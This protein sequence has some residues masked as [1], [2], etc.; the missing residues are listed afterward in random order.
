M[1]DYGGENAVSLKDAIYH[2]LK[3]YGMDEETKSKLL[4]GVCCDGAAVNLGCVKGITRINI[5][6]FP[7]FI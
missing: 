2:C 1:N 6:L 5:Q 7:Y 4:I 3:F